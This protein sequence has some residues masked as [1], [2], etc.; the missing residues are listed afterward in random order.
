MGRKPIDQTGNIYGKWVVLRKASQKNSCGQVCWICRCECGNEKIV[1]GK[2]LR[3]GKSKSCGECTRHII[4]P[5]DKFG[6]L[7]VIKEAYVDNNHHK[8]WT[9]KCEC[10]KIVDVV[11]S[12]LIRGNSK[13]CGCNKAQ[14]HNLLGKKFG[15]LTVIED[16]GNDSYGNSLW[17][18]KC[19]CGNV[20]IIR[21]A[22]LVNCNTV[23]CGCQK[24]SKGEI[25]I[26][27]ILDKNNIKYLQEYRVPEI[28]N[29]RFDFAILNDNGKI[30]QLIE[31]D[32]IQHYEEWK[33]E[34]KTTLKE[35]QESDRIKN[36]WAKK[37]NIPLI[38]IPYWEIDNI[39]LNMLKINNN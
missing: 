5:G 6:K 7:T 12:N 21:G 14:R 27:E 35:R 9:C 25:K 16:A 36:E 31:F 20:K 30:I 33:F 18:C 23:T 11:G 38:R 28:N 29:K 3:R 8:R 4:K 15:L 26:K 2:V 37:N 32:G 34:R 1:S 22:N 24:M 13:S 39:N 17:K 19:D 10:G